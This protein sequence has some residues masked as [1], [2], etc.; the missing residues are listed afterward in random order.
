MAPLTLEVP[1]L[2]AVAGVAEAQKAPMPDVV[3]MLPSSPPTPPT[4]VSLT[5]YTVLDRTAADLGRLREDL[6]G[7]D[8]RL[9]VGRLE[10]VSGWVRSDASVRAALSQAVPALDKEKQATS[11]AKA[12]RDAALG[13]A[14]NG[15]S[16][17]KAVEASCKA[18]A[19][20]ST[21]RSAAARRRRRS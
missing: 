11:Q 6:Q 1:A 10:L 3:I 20:S 13:D 7:A 18:C 16:R 12:A 5:P 14:A 15:R 21:G 9:V 4:A 19:M 17:C 2:D 8:P